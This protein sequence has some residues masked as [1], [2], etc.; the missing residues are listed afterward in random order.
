[1]LSLEKADRGH[2][3]TSHTGRSDP[4]LIKDLRAKAV[5]SL[6]RTR[7]KNSSTPTKEA[8]NEANKVGSGTAIEQ[9]GGQE[10]AKGSQPTT[11][12]HGQEKDMHQ[13]L[14]ELLA[15]A[16]AEAAANN[17]LNSMKQTKEQS[18]TNPKG[19]MKAS[20][21]THPSEH[22]S[23]KSRQESAN[24]YGNNAHEA[25]TVVTRHNRETSA[26]S[27]LGE[28]VEDLEM[29]KA[30][31][32]KPEDEVKVKSTPVAASNSYTSYLQKPSSTAM[33]DGQMVKRNTV[34]IPK[35][36]VERTAVSESKR[37]SREESVH[38]LGANVST[39]TSQP[40]HWSDDSYRP[41]EPRKPSVGTVVRSS[42][43]M[44]GPSRDLYIRRYSDDRR[45]TSR[46]E[47]SPP[48]VVEI[49]DREDHW[50]EHPRTT[51]PR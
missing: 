9:P 35:T 27:E 49:T 3:S 4:Q 24:K 22:E 10:N 38:Q 43:D 7:E 6:Q 25:K 21:E 13:D 8:L 32:P 37:Y 16:K 20:N 41:T 28:I 40:K 23:K 14:D 46:R 17:H 31:P 18:P 26:T 11:Q 30:S 29:T 51:A 39:R 15:Q 48:R 47:Y 19:Y 33:D 5:A 2:S 44:K 1:M 12:L 42:N 50:D 45:Q 34:E 36:L